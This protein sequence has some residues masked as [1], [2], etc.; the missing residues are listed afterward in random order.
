MIRQI[1][2]EEESVSSTKLHNSKPK[3]R[4]VLGTLSLREVQVVAPVPSMEW[5]WLMRT[6]ERSSR[7]LSIE[8]K[9]VMTI[10][11]LYPSS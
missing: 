5:L 3:R 7:M 4:Q 8:S 11:P 6:R 2:S 9:L 1:K 10:T